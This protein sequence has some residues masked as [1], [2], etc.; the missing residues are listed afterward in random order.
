MHTNTCL[1]DSMEPNAVTKL[2]SLGYLIGTQRVFQ[3]SSL[4]LAYS[5]AGLKAVV[6]SCF[7]CFCKPGFMCCLVLQGQSPLEGGLLF[8][9]TS[10]QFIHPTSSRLFTLANLDFAIIENQAAMH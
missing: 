3:L 7:L 4:Q 10:R 6:P 8:L 2:L 1:C 5:N 9:Q